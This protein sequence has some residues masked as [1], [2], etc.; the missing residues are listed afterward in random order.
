MAGWQCGGA[1]RRHDLC[2]VDAGYQADIAY[3]FVAESGVN[4]YIAAK[5]LGTARD[6]AGWRSPKPGKDCQAGNEWALVRQPNGMALL[7]VNTDF[8]KA[9][10]H[11]GFAAPPSSAGSLMLYRAQRRD[12]MTFARQI[13]AEK[14]QEEFV[15]G[16]GRRLYWDKIR[17]DNHYLDCAVGARVAA[18]VLGITLIGGEPAA[19]PAPRARRQR[20]EGKSWIDTQDNWMGK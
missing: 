20:E 5:G 8:W 18:D 2:A 16:R 9:Q 14:Q 12:H 1:E 17:R 11:Q 15:P 6:Q 13:V 3:E 19:A 10:V 7:N 4:S